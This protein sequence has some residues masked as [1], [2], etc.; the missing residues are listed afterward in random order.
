MVECV[1]VSRD[2]ERETLSTV[3]KPYVKYCTNQGWL[4]HGFLKAYII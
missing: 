2:F 3:F 4:Y 1:C